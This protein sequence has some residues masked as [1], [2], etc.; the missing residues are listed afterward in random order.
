MPS[1][2]I[3]N[4]YGGQ[5]PEYYNAFGLYLLG[6]TT[7]FDTPIKKTESISVVDLQSFLPYRFLSDVSVVL[8]L[9]QRLFLT[10]ILEMWRISSSIRG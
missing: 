7:S 8:G 1:M 3:I 6:K 4:S 9:P 2:G 5:T 10:L